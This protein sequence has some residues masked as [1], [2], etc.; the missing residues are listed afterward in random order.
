MEAK[1]KKAIIFFIFV[2]AIGAPL[3][4]FKQSIYPE[5]VPKQ[6]FF[7]AVVEIVFFLWLA[8]ALIDKKYRPRKTP[9][10]LSLAA[11]LLLLIL[12]SFTG[13][14][15]QRSFWSTYE[16]AIGVVGILH[17]AALAFVI[18]SLINEL[19][20][21]KLF[22][23][24][25][26]T[27]LIINVIAW[28]Q[29]K[30]PNLL[31]NEA[32]GTRPGATFGNP[33]FL[34][35]YL[36]FNI[37]I[38]LYLWFYESRLG[39]GKPKLLNQA[40]ALVSAL[41]SVITIFITQT[42]GDILALGAGFVF[43]LIMLAVRPPGVTVK[44]LC[45]RYL[46]VS[47]I[48]V[49]FVGG[50]TFWF[51]RTNDFW[52]K[53]PGLSRFRDISFSLSSPDIQ[54]RLYALEAAS[55]GFLE[56][57]IV[58]WGWENFNIVYNK[59]YNPKSLESSYGET[60]FDKP[61][62]F[63]FEY[64][65]SGGLLLFLSYFVLWG[66][67]IYEALKAKDKFLGGFVVAALASN[68]VHNFFVFE[69][70]GPLLIFYVLAGVVDGE[71]R[72]LKLNGVKE[73]IFQKPPEHF[74]K[75]VVCAAAAVALI[76]LYFVNFLTAQAAYHEFWAFQNLVNNRV[77]EGIYDFKQ[78][79]FAIWSPYNW[80]IKRDYAIAV[81]E[82]YFYNPGLI[83]D[84]QVVE[85]VRAMEEARDEHPLDAYNHYALVD[86]YNEI[87]DINPSL[88]LKE[89]EEETQT[90]LRLSPNRQEVYFSLAKTKTLEG[91]YQGATD[92]L[93]YALNLNPKVPDAHFYYGLLAFAQGDMNS[94]YTEI[95]TAIEM[96]RPWKNYYEPRTVANFFAQSG[97]L[98]EARDLYTT[99]LN[100]SRNNDLDSE[101]KLG[102]V[103]YFL[104]DYGL[105]KKYL[106][107][108]IQKFN[109]KNSPSWS[110]LKPILDSLGIAVP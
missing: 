94:G 65:A 40:V 74:H 88:Y 72:N 11:F 108:A 58:G 64:L 60:R 57:P 101:I 3:F 102:V 22:Y 86:L 84:E 51:T 31:L 10:L 37:F 53:V 18:S 82:A 4:Y 80:N 96:G 6:V 79:S 56:K 69:T 73:A 28:I 110:Q 98:T 32:V 33:T 55:K 13:A 90:A 8:L 42:R 87:S 41:A 15:I 67:F 35:G 16:R 91:N 14:D 95:K 77:T 46:Y 92:L 105:A 26:L 93:K 107:G 47:L 68:F 59:Y 25:L 70:L 81:A 44:I 48:A 9:L 62:N 29:L 5:I 83:S 34:A 104:G 21:R 39:S 61:H 99:A 36:L 50:L 89:A 54:P 75:Y 12:T 45:S 7:Q 17:F 27:A 109:V 71:Y 66:F 23:A 49:I 52:L 20:W 76:I 2:A 63:V 1:L 78:S 30:V 106:S 100:M 38:G 103:Y 43:L 85:A 19:P 24:S 97:H